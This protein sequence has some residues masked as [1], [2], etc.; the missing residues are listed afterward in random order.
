MVVAQQ[1]I[2]QAKALARQ[3]NSQAAIALL[4]KLI[5][6]NASDVEAWLALA[7]VVEEPDRVEFCLQKVQNLDPGN[8][9][10]LEKLSRLK[11]GKGDFNLGGEVPREESINAAQQRDPA[12]EHGH[13][14]APEE[15]ES[16]S[17]PDAF[18]QDYANRV[19]SLETSA[20]P[21]KQT[22]AGPRTQAVSRSAALLAQN[23]LAQGGKLLSSFG[24]TDLILIGLTLFAGL[25]LFS[26]VG[27]AVI[28]KSLFSSQPAESPD[29]VVQVVFENIIAAN[30]ED[31]G[32]YMATIHPD[33]PR[34]RTE[35]AMIQSAFSLYDL[36][37]EIFI[38]EMLEQ[39]ES[40]AVISFVLT[41]RK[42]RGPAF[43]DNTVTGEM[44]LRKHEG[45]WKI[46]DKRLD[47][48]QYLN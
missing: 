13:R 28:G 14:G 26:L 45:E 27:A 3:G 38:P 17:Q 46:F 6:R 19:Q 33:S 20:E 37:Y 30:R 7:D 22:A 10:A 36:S 41:T 47:D 2:E 32:A 11:G 31:L 35:Q 44:T 12:A 16:A 1:E 18:N 24:R 34:Y 15:I 29:E 23:L 4:S 25:V 43:Q 8:A 21:A 9:A 48:L 39:G 40:E 42:V 5:R